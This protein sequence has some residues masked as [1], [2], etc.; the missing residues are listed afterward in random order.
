MPVSRSDHHLLC[1]L[2]HRIL[3]SVVSSTH[4]AITFWN[5]VFFFILQVHKWLASCYRWIHFG[6]S[7]M[8]LNRSLSSTANG[9][10]LW[11]ICSKLN[12][13]AQRMMTE[14]GTDCCLTYPKP[15][16]WGDSPK[17]VCEVRNSWNHHQDTK[18]FAS[19]FA[20]MTGLMNCKLPALKE[21]PSLHSCFRPAV[22][23]FGSGSKLCCFIVFT[24]GYS[25]TTNTS[26]V[27]IQDSWQSTII[28]KAYLQ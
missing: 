15:V 17:S 24:H 19:P 1:D 4:N 21:S 14:I 25:S 2:W 13:S 28:H 12:Q 8:N 9:G 3:P 6:C 27:R 18:I 5:D 20:R 22:L 10:P 16:L 11:E 7:K 23:V 26:T